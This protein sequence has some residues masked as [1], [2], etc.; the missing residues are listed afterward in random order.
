[1]RPICFKGRIFR[2]KLG[3]EK[4]KPAPIEARVPLESSRASCY[5]RKKLVPKSCVS[6]SL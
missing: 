1:M 3:F 2:K 5:R 4:T 6:P